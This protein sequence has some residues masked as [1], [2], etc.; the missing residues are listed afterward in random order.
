MKTFFSE[1]V[2]WKKLENQ[3]IKTFSIIGIFLFYI[4]YNL[5]FNNQN[6]VEMPFLEL[7][8][9]LIISM[10]LGI[11]VSGVILYGWFNIEQ[12]KNSLLNKTEILNF[13][14]FLRIY[15]LYY[16]IMLPIGILF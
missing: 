7:L 15:I 2:I 11:F 14:Y 9:G 10:S 6:N 16:L 3:K 8:L 1:N 12:K 5:N 13:D 4:I